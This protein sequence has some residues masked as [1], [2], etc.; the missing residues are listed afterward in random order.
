MHLQTALCALVSLIETASWALF[1]A[2]EYTYWA[3]YHP[4]AL[5]GLLCAAVG[6]AVLVL[7]NAA[8]LLCYCKYA[9]PDP[10]FA[11][12]LRSYSCTN[13]TL[14]FL[15]SAYT[16][17]LYRLVHSKLLGRNELSMQL[18]SPNK[19]VPFS[20]VGVLSIL[21]CSAPLAVGCALALYNSISQ[22]QEFFIALDILTLT[23]VMVLLLL[24][25]LRHPDDYFSD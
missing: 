3:N 15:A 2:F 7:L 12:W 11:R 17:K 9:L 16:F 1:A 20:L 4:T 10:E 5:F 25:D 23:G 18:A 8:H 21:G 14:I 19:L 13:R 24:L 22:D 6:L